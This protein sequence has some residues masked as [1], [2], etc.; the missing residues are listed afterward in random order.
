MEIQDALTLTPQ[1]LY[2]GEL[3]SCHDQE[4][5]SQYEIAPIVGVRR[6][7]VGAWLKLHANKGKNGQQKR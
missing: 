6:R 5:R 2:K 4:R 3:Q 7:T 1:A